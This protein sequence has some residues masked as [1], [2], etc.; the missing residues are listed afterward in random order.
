M[1]TA[2]PST[3][4]LDARTSRNRRESS[5]KRTLYVLAAVISLVVFVVPLLWALMRSFQPNAVTTA[6]PDPATFFHLSFGN[7]RGITTFGTIGRAVGNSLVV[8]VGAAIL[9]TLVAT[10]AGYGFGSFRFRGATVAFALI[11]VTMMV[12]FQ[13]IIT[14]LFMELNAMRLTNNLLGLVLF[15]TTVNLPFGVFVM[16]TAFLGVPVE[17]EEAANVDGAGSMRTLVSVVRPLVVPG[18]ATTALYAFLASWTEFLGALTFLT[19]QNLYTLP[20]ALLNLQQG[21]YG[22]I[23]FGYLSAG[24]VVA[25]IPCVVLFLALQR[26]YVAGLSS[27]AVKG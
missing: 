22:S 1:A 16:R 8:S 11:L 9:T 19:D 7:F 6:P 3:S 23:D 4:G 20:V 13:A 10:A 17:L 18:M 21:A 2:A 24:A 5:A 25:M 14:P 12:P 15:Y 26:Y 27:G